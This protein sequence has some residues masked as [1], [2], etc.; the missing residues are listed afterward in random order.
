V[1]DEPLRGAIEAPVGGT[2]VGPGIVRVSGWIVPARRTLARVEVRVDHRS[3]GLARLFAQDRP[4]IAAAIPDAAAPVAGFEHLIAIAGDP[5]ARVLVEVDFEDVDG[6]TGTL[7]PVEVTIGPPAQAT[8]TPRAA[9]GRSGPEAPVS[10]SS[11]PRRSASGLRLVAFTHRLDVGGGQLYLQELLVELLKDPGTSCLVISAGDGPLRT[12]LEE[13]GATVCIT[14]FP[15]KTIEAYE[16]R[17]D[18]L[19]AVVRA[20]GANVAFVNTLVAGPGADLVL[21]LGIPAVWV[22]REPLPLDEF[23][24]VAYGIDGIAA[25]VRDA[26]VRAVA[27]TSVVVFDAEE[28]RRLHSGT[29]GLERGLVVP[30]GVPLEEIERFRRTVD[31]CSARSMIGLVDDEQLVL[32]VGI[33]APHKGQAAL[34][35]AFA[36][37]AEEFPTA[38][39]AFVGDPATSYSRAVH[40]VVE[41]LGLRDRVRIEATNDQ[42]YVWYRSADAFVLP[43]DMESMPRVMLE[44]LAFELPSAMCA[45]GGISELVTDGR[46]GMLFAR[47]DLRAQ[48]EAIRRLLQLT[49]EERAR[50]GSTGAADVRRRHDPRIAMSKLRTLLEELATS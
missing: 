21:R 26:I 25:E 36:E 28:T 1:T 5:Y 23:W 29:S 9:D 3:M 44:A 6:T 31:R 4:D 39:L 43:S 22:V 2:L 49:A 14:D 16:A 24:P 11:R 30:H 41:R 40:Q 42:P 17:L 27:R 48:V 10:T 50:L 34:L 38:R 33:I 32:N 37:V 12:Q 35:L 46:N 20:H 18:E 8:R 45:V 13:L 15:T 19:A 7:S 47:R